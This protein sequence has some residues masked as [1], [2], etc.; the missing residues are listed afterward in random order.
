MD[1]TIHVL[2]NPKFQASIFFSETQSVCDCTGQFVLDLVGNPTTSFSR[3]NCAFVFTGGA[4]YSP[5]LTD[6]M[7]M[8]KVSR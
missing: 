3:L 4:V 7:F 8:V 1:S 5:A 6:F 2:F